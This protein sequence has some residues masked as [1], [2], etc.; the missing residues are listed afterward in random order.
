V[1]TTTVGLAVERSGSLELGFIQFN[2][3]QNGLDNWKQP[4]FWVGLGAT[5][6]T[7]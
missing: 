7:S 5:R 2:A 1:T 4:A 6:S 3:M